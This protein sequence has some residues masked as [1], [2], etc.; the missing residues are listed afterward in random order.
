MNIQSQAPA[1]LIG[2]LGTSATLALVNQIL[3]T[4]AGVL[5]ILVLSCTLYDRRKKGRAREKS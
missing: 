1:V 3:V 2:A 4:I 5:T